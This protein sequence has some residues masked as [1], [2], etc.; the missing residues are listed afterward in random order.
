MWITIENYKPPEGGNDGAPT[1]QPSS[2]AASRSSSFQAA[3]ET[4]PQA[5]S[6][7]LPLRTQELAN[8]SSQAFESTDLRRTVLHD[9]FRAGPFS[10]NTLQPSSSRVALHLQE[11]PSD[12]ASLSRSTTMSY[13]S[14]LAPTAYNQP[15]LDPVGSNR[16]RPMPPTRT[17]SMLNIVRDA[18][19]S[20]LTDAELRASC[21]LVPHTYNPNS[22]L[23]SL[24]QRKP[25][26]ADLQT[27]WHSG[28]QKRSR[29]KE[30]IERHLSASG[31]GVEDDA[32][33]AMGVFVPMFENL[34]WYSTQKS[35]TIRQ[36]VPIGRWNAGVAQPATSNKDYFARF[37]EPPEWCIDRNMALGAGKSTFGESKVQ[38]FFGELEWVKA[39]ERVG[40]DPRYRPMI[41]RTNSGDLGGRRGKLGGSVFGPN[42]LKNMP[43]MGRFG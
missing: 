27:F 34:H 22:F 1:T 25:G 35:L 40:R 42:S 6:T 8:L 26:E 7:T 28:Q 13:G 20:S 32:Q 37:V 10:S 21:P 3:T 4:Q 9:P 14:G 18:K 43:S 33:A 16:P 12:Y 30:Y 31:K 15:N 17:G 2:Y 38:T 23:A 29:Q 11:Y 39:P 36:V 41:S 19:P 24:P 5:I